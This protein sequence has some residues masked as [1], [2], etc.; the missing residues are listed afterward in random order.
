MGTV[1]FYLAEAP[2][3]VHSRSVDE[4]W[5]EENGVTFLHLQVNPRMLWVV[6]SDSMIHLVDTA[7]RRHE[8][9]FIHTEI[10]LFLKP[11]C[12]GSQ[13]VTGIIGGTLVLSSGAQKVSFILKKKKPY[14]NKKV[15]LFVLL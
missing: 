12:I 2:S 10:Q 13:T 14:K 1:V 9:K 11:S 5:V 6:V 4:Q 7:L 15:G 3:L 8:Y